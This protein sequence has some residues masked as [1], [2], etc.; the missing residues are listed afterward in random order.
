MGGVVLHVH[1]FVPSHSHWNIYLSDAAGGSHLTMSPHCCDAACPHMVPVA[2][3]RGIFILHMMSHHYE[4]LTLQ[5]CIVSTGF[6]FCWKL[7]VES[8]GVNSYFLGAAGLRTCS[9]VGV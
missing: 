8:A 3:F 2:F 5:D 7:S 4:L 6:S 9:S 1:I